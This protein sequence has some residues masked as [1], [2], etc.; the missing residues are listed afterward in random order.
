MSVNRKRDVGQQ[1][2]LNDGTHVSRQTL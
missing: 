1:S 2:V